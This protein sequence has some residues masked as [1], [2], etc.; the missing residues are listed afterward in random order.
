MRQT[1][2]IAQFD[3]HVTTLNIVVH[4]RLINNPM[5]STVRYSRTSTRSTTSPATIFLLKY[6]ARIFGRSTLVCC[7]CVCVC[8]CVQS[9]NRFKRFNENEHISKWTT[10]ESQEKKSSIDTCSRQQIITFY[11]SLSSLKATEA[12]C[13]SQVI[14]LVE[15]VLFTQEKKEN[16]KWWRKESTSR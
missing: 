4:C 1:I 5:I 6:L 3:D 15:F 12:K 14:Y 2:A 7:Q 13:A 8:A 10:S 9:L 11:S 16:I